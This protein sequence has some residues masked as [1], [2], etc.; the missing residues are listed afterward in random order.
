[1]KK[2]VKGDIFYADLE[3]V[4]KYDVIGYKPV[5]I[6]HNHGVDEFSNIVVAP[7]SALKYRKQ[8]IHI[9]LEQFSEIRPNSYIMLDQIRVLDK[10][11]LKGYIGTLAKEQLE[12]IDKI[13]YFI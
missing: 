12:E 4:S 5:L 6:I 2:I 1:M 3:G 9:L 7:I 8:D 10:K 11:K 13:I